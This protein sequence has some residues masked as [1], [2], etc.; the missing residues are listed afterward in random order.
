[1]SKEQQ[2]QQRAAIVEQSRR[3]LQRRAATKK[4]TGPMFESDVAEADQKAIEIHAALRNGA[5]TQEQAAEAMKR[6]EQTEYEMQKL[7][8]PSS[9]AGLT[10]Q[11][12][13][14]HSRK[15]SSPHAFS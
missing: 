4:G 1:M 12:L 9:N 11:A 7:K 14:F 6:N 15:Q 8:S 13:T 2:I 5:I 3:R 10:T